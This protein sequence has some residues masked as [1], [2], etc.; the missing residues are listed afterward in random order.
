MCTREQPPSVSLC[1][2]GK[3][4]SLDHTK[5]VEIKIA[6]RIEFQEYE[7]MHSICDEVHDNSDETRNI[8]VC[9]IWKCGGG[10]GGERVALS[11]KRP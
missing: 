10:G 7:N 8:S 2:F 6:P 3:P 4:Q 5:T 9:D 11:L 1:Q